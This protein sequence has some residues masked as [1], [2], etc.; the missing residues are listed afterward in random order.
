M[1]NLISRVIA[2]FVIIF[3]LALCF[4]SAE[5]SA[6]ENT[7]VN[8][9][10]NSSPVALQITCDELEGRSFKNILDKDSYSYF[11]ATAD[12][13]LNVKAAQPVKGIYCMFEKPCNWTLT[14]PDG[15]TRNEGA[16]EIIHKYIPLETAITDFAI[17]LPENGKLTDIYAFSSDTPPDWVQ[18]W[19]PP[20]EKADLLLMPTHADDEHLWFGGAMPYYAG[21]L[22]YKVQV[23]YLTSHNNYTLRNHER[24]NGLWTVGVRNYPIVTNKFLDILVTKF[25][26]EDAEREFGYNNV[27]EFQVEMLRRFSPKVIIAHDING[28]Y[29]HGAHKLNASTLLDALQIYENPSVFPESAQKYG[30]HKVQKCYLHLWPE[31]RIT[32]TWSKKNLSHFNGTSS[33]EMAIK[34]YLCHRSQAQ[35]NNFVR[36]YGRY[37]CRKFGLAYTTVGYDTPGLNDMF[38]H[39]DMSDNND[40]DRNQSDTPVTE[41]SDDSNDTSS[42]TNDEKQPDKNVSDSDLLAYFNRAKISKKDLMIA[43]AAMAVSLI[44]IIYVIVIKKRENNVVS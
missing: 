26:L 44:A 37:D 23:V 18:V 36:E 38:E 4:S 28:E 22:G 25:S 34:G 27:L 19:E 2:S 31:N 7:D 6:S 30:I 3:S 24:L 33:L 5:V 21:E 13:C 8:E 43:L 42:G 20:C 15:T 12:I 10:V 29:G 39:V 9:L 40:D 17:H 16:D 14:L 32:V 11:R 41:E 35:F 1:N